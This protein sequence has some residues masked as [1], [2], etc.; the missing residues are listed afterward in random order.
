MAFC[1]GSLSAQE[2]GQLSGDFT[3]NSNFFLKD[4]TIFLDQIPPQY[5]KQLSSAESWLYLDYRVSGFD[6]TVRFDAFQNSGLINPQE[7]YTEQGLG[8]WSIS[9]DFGDLE[10]T[11]GSFYD[12]IGNGVLLRSY[13]DR[14]LGF[15]NAIQGARVK[16]NLNDQYTFMG[17][18]G[19]LKRRFEYFEQVL[20]G[21][22]AEG[23]FQLDSAARVTLF[24]GL[25]VLNRT[26]D[27]KSMQEL[28]ST[29]NLYDLE[30]RFIPKYNVYAFSQYNTLTLGPVNLNTEVAYKTREAI[31]NQSGNQLINSD[32]IFLQSALS[33]SA[34]GFGAS[35]QYRYSNNFVIRTKPTL[36][37]DPNVPLQGLVTVLTPIN[38]QN[39]KR[40]P[41]RYS[42]AAFFFG[43]NGYQGEIT[44]S[45]DKA[46]TLTLNYSDVREDGGG[47][48]Y[49]EYFGK[50][51]HRFNREWKAGGGLQRLKYNQFSYEQQFAELASEQPIVNTW[52]P[53]AEVSWR[54]QPR[55]SVRVEAQ[56]LSTEQDQGSFAFGL[57][58]YSIAPK[59]TF[60]AGDMVN[61][62]PLIN[63]GEREEVDVIHYYTGA[64]SYTQKQ[65][66]LMGSFVKQPQGVNCTGGVCRVEPAFSGFRFQMTT[67]F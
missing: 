18:T 36:L 49:E 25:G 52:T 37:L 4:T 54:F 13:E 10:I 33:Y 29:I 32:G 53:F 42:P 5:T 44:W 2:K 24:S 46:N 64:I 31:L 47:R 39:V 27:D 17:F 60:S 65:T 22:Y 19:R 51:E 11:G 50:L 3:L 66:R 57:M 61:L 23:F 15:D 40:L 45:P 63:G 34:P 48:L 8:F 16:Y 9:K 28:A 26:L 6:F 41:A 1:S 20:K 21:G 43:E 55:K 59:W 62:N 14:N 56:Y 38:R 67:N 7:A 12:Q 35:V 58:E 30:D